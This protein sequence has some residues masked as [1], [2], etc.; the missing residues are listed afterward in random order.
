MQ[1]KIEFTSEAPIAT[2]IPKAICVGRSATFKLN[3]W[4]KEKDQ[5]KS[6]GAM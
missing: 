1:K 6:A 4:N 3:L 2:R 5:K